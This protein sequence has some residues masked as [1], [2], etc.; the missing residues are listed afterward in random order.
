MVITW[1]MSFAEILLD[2]IKT[3]IISRVRGIYWIKA[4]NEGIE[5]GGKEL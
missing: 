4:N 2:S 5:K 3:E 1:W